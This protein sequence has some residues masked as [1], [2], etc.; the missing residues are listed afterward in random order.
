MEKTSTAIA[1]EAECANA[2]TECGSTEQS[3]AVNIEEEDA[4]C[5]RQQFEEGA[6]GGKDTGNYHRRICRLLDAILRHCRPAARLR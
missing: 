5:E 1:A 3:E 4:K 2:R 6:K